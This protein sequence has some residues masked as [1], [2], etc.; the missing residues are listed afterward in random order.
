M[1]D[2]EQRREPEQEDGISFTRLRVTD[3]LSNKRVG[4]P[5]RLGEEDEVK[6]ENKKCKVVQIATGYKKEVRMVGNLT[7]K[8]ELGRKEIEEGVKEKD[9]RLYSTDKSG[10]L[11]LDTNENY[12]RTQMKH[13][14]GGIRR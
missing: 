8:E 12:L 13:V 2:R 5:P 10:K 3:F 7:E 4:Q 14:G 1:S 11:V 6:V 9:W